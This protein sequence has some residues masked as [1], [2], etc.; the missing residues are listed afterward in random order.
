MESQIRSAELLVK[1][2]LSDPAVLKK[3]Q[4]D[5]EATLKA[6]E[7][8]TVQQLPRLSLPDDITTNRIWIVIAAPLP[9][10]CCIASG[11]WGAASTWL[12]SLPP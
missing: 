11:Y 9:W 3:I 10:S 2:A 5:P 4:D 8:E 12:I 1:N 7:K 6:L